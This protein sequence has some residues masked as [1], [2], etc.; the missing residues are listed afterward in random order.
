MVTEEYNMR[1]KY[2]WSDGC[3]MECR[4]CF[5]QMMGYIL[6]Q[7][8][9]SQISS[10]GDIDAGNPVVYF[11]PVLSWWTES[12]QQRWGPLN[13]GTPLNIVDK[14]PNIKDSYVGSY[15]DM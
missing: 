2:Y 4:G 10:V 15:Q 11:S 7:I 5:I 9:M 6:R 14:T 3:S 12:I 8:K 13:R 1:L